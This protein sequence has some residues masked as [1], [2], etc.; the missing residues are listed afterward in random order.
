M[1]ASKKGTELE[2]K[3]EDSLRLRADKGDI[4]VIALSSFKEMGN[5]INAHIKAGRKITDENKT[6]LIPINET[7]FSNGEAKTRLPKSVRGRE[8]FILCDVGNYSCTYNMCGY[9]N[10]KSPDDHFQDLKRVISAICGKAVS[11]TVVMPLVYASR[12]D[13][14][15]GRESLDCA[16]ALQELERMGVDRIVTFDIH[17]SRVQNAVPLISFDN[18]YATYQIVTQ[19]LEDEK[20]VAIHN[21]NLVIISPDAGGMD[22]ALYYKSVLDAD[23]SFFYKRRDTNRICNGGNPIV[24]HEFVG[25]PV[26]DKNILI[27]DDMIGS[28]QSIIDIMRELKAQG[29]KKIFVAVTFSLFTLGT[30]IFDECYKEGLFDKIY[31]TN[32][33]YL[34][35]ELK[36]VEW[37]KEVDMAESLAK[38]IDRLYHN[39]SIKPFVNATEALTKQ[40]RQLREKS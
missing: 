35:P 32:L 27:V 7:R 2:P 28:G 19:I 34:S 33:T 31:S 22:R 26:R 25:Q 1:T 37:F 21:E 9:E 29:A 23:V 12:Q 39:R 30:K 38:I 15:K 40:I 6:Y 11:L 18:L 36:N 16:I 13:K 14:R 20:E 5:K 3:E 17:D 8:I 10:H 24:A 4:G